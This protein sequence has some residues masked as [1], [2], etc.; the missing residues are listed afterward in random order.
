[1]PKKINI[2]N[3]ITG[4]KNVSD[5]LSTRTR[6][7]LEKTKDPAKNLVDAVNL[8]LKEA[9]KVW[10]EEGL[11][12]LRSNLNVTQYT[13]HVKQL[14]DGSKG[15][16]ALL[17][18]SQN[19]WFRKSA[20]GLGIGLGL[21]GLQKLVGSYAPQPVIPKNY[22]RGYDIMNQTITDF[23]SPVKLLKTASKII[24][25]YYSSVRKGVVT[26]TSTVMDK[27]ISL[28]LNKKAIGHTRY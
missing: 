18:I 24:T 19:K 10:K 6:H 16:Q 7:F 25:P 8:S 21:M 13:K 4:T 12:A 28:L 11:S 23:G 14:M 2:D 17:K 22:D 20:I 9:Q 3:V 27:N 1:M 15:G 5:Y 26:T